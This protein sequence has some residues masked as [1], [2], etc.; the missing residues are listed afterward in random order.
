MAEIFSW[1]RHVIYLSVFLVVILQLLPDQKYRKYVGFFACLLFVSVVAAPLLG[2][3][4]EKH[5]EESILEQIRISQSDLDL[6][7]FESQRTSVYGRGMVKAVQTEIAELAEHVGLQC[8]NVQVE[9]ADDQS[10][11]SVTVKLSGIHAAE[12]EKQLLGQILARYQLEED[13]VEVKTDG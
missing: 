5:L 9:L 4:D 7:D 2:N 12:K 11:Q 3:W 6:A 13:Q 8:R 10:I 1:V